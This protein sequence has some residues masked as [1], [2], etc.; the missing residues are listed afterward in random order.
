MHRSRTSPAIAALTL[1]L[2]APPAWAGAEVDFG[3]GSL[4]IDYGILRAVFD[5]GEKIVVLFDSKKQTLTIYSEKDKVYTS[6]GIAKLC[7]ATKPLLAAAKTQNREALQSDGDFIRFDSGRQYIDADNR[8]AAADAEIVRGEGSPRLAGEPVRNYVAL[9]KGE[10]YASF[11][12]TTSKKIRKYTRAV[13][14]EALRR[15]N[16]CGFGYATL[17]NGTFSDEHVEDGPEWMKLFRDGLLVRM[18][19]IDEGQADVATRIEAKS[20]PR[21]YFEV[22]PGYTEVP[23]KDAIKELALEL[24]D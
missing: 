20:H 14:W 3:D 10:P 15:F 12:I 7:K 1:C 22:P 13:D 24:T 8:A 6:A 2:I 16:R 18:E 23:F 19:L 11:S 9:V 5:D 21:S 4:A 17:L